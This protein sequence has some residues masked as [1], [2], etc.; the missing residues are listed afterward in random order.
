MEGEVLKVTTY[1]KASISL[2]MYYITGM[3][4][5]K[6]RSLGLQ[7]SLRI[8]HRRDQTALIHI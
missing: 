5:G 1:L 6:L 4:R 8:I 2:D 7:Q 3:A